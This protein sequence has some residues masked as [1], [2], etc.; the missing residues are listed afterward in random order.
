MSVHGDEL[1]KQL[2]RNHPAAI[3]VPARKDVLK[4]RGKYFLQFPDAFFIPL[5][6]R[7]LL[8]FFALD[9]ASPHHDIE[10]FTCGWLAD[11]ESLGDGKSR[12][13]H[14]LQDLRQSG[15]ETRQ[16]AVSATRESA[17]AGHWLERA[18]LFP[19]PYLF[20]AKYRNIML[21]RVVLV[22]PSA[23]QAGSSERYIFQGLLR[24]SASVST[25]DANSSF[26]SLS[27][28]ACTS[29]AGRTL[30]SMPLRSNVAVASSTT[31]VLKPRLPAIR[32][33]VNTQWFVVKPTM[34][35]VEIPRLR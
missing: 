13:P 6:E 10:V 12:K 2:A 28:A 34:T 29:A 24:R 32:A 26:R 15:E 8:Y 25:M 27:A 31:K 21:T 22:A 1:R 14:P 19:D 16:R 23:L 30:P 4:I 20:L 3:I 18:T 11:L 9:Q 17:N 7:P 33:V 5:I 35:S